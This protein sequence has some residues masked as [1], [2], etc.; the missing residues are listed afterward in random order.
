MTTHD[1]T[2]GDRLPRV[3]G[4]GRFALIVVGL[5]I[6]TAVFRVPSL[7]AARTGSPG[8]AAVVWIGGAVFAFAGG[9]CAAELAVRI[10]KAGGEYALIK[11]TYGDRTGFVY[12]WT[13]LLLV[14]PASIAAV[15]RT[16]ADYASTV[17][18]ISEPGRRVL[19]V[20]VIT[21]HGALAMASTR[22]ASRFIGAATLGKLTA[23]ALVVIAAF[24]F[25]AAGA[26]PPPPLPLTAGTSGALIA[27]VVA[28][29]WAYDGSS[30][31][32]LAG[33]VKDPARSLPRGLLVGTSIVVTVYLLL[34]VAY[35]RTLGFA[36]VAASD[37]VAADAMG[38]LV[39]R[40]GAL[41]VAGLVM[42]SSY[43]CGMVQLVGHPRVTFAL[44][45]DGLFF[46]PFATVSPRT[47]TPWIAILLHATLAAVLATLGGYEFLIRLTVFAFYP[48]LTATYVGAVVLRRR[49]GAP[50]GFRMPFYPLPVVVYV[51]TMSFVMVV[52]L[53]DDPAALLYSAAVM[54]A[55]WLAYRYRT[56]EPRRTA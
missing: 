16:F 54:S 23:M 53:I 50:T 13:W 2:A 8:L 48:L 31:I 5:T 33:D 49:D 14:S 10:P 41:L 22:W 26:T 56:S 25:P 35:G 32:F 51:V 34:N 24:V 12:G 52:S 21:L 38:A 39:G 27:A 45:D 9:L 43:S 29:I 17:A 11:A 44:A 40:T 15:A 42:L 20:L 55:G 4:T 47:H 18:P 19:T 30:Q 28:V 3:I 1:T 36:G 6:G 7:I 37:A 46:R